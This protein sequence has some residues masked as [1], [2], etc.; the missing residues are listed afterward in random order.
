MIPNSE[1]GDDVGIMEGAVGTDVDGLDVGITD[2]DALGI[3]VLVKFEMFL[4]V[5]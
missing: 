5:H 1:V 4:N 2:G 3:G